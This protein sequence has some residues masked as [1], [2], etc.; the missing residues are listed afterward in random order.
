MPILRRMA[1]MSVA[2]DIRSTPPKMIAPPLGSSRRL[3][4]RSKVLLP[5]PDGPMMKTSSCGA[6]FRSMPRSTSVAPNVLRSARTCRIGSLTDGAICHSG[7]ARR[8]GPGIHNHGIRGSIDNPVVMGSGLAAFAAPRNDKPTSIALRLV[9]G[10]IVARHAGHAVTREHRDGGGAGRWLDAEPLLVH[11]R[12]R[13]VELHALD[14]VLDRLAQL[15]RILAQRRAP[16]QPGRVQVRQLELRIVL[17]RPGDHGIARDVGIG[18]TGKHRLHGVGLGTAA[19]D[20]PADL[21]F[22]LARSWIAG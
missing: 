14:R 5:E 19:P 18:A 17:H 4:Q 1:L 16:D 7:T 21:G 10:R 9:L 15:G 22:E 13:A 12:D 20:L 8:A 2:R 11:R 6:T 3:Q